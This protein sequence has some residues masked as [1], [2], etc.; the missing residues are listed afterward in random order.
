MAIQSK[1]GIAVH[2]CG[3]ESV[4]LF[5]PRHMLGLSCCTQLYIISLGLQLSVARISTAPKM[6][7]FCPMSFIWFQNSTRQLRCQ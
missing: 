7:T 5:I 3:F 2:L 6:P 4:I 1:L